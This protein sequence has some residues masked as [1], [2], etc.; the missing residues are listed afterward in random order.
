MNK[1]V[2]K[3]IGITLVAILICVAIIYGVFAL[4]FPKK[5]AKFYDGLGNDV[6]A[7]K[8]MDTAY[9]K[10]GD[11]D[12]LDKLCMYAVKSGDNGLIAQHLGKLFED[13]TFKNYCLNGNGIEYYD[14]MASR[15][16]TSFYQVSSDKNAV[17][18]KAFSLTDNYRE[19]SAGYTITRVC[20]SSN[21]TKEVATYL[22]D[23][24]TNSLS[25]YDE[26]AQQLANEDLVNINKY[27][28][29]NLI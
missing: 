3:T 7:I 27:I 24:L 13:E 6:L 25:S 9:Q 2:L 4:F 26:T 18:D 14:F 5:M 16:V 11:I 12:D 15:F 23:K 8:F 22:K 10:S 21:P 28:A 17:I 20:I 1:L 19:L 29:K